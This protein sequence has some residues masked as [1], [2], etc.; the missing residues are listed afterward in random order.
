MLTSLRIFT[1]TFLSTTQLF[2]VTSHTCASRGYVIG[3]GV[4]FICEPPQS[5]NGTLAIKPFQT[6]AVD[7]SSNL[8]TRS[9][10]AHSRNAF[11][12]E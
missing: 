8:Q 12:I 10:T 2:L 5:L 9:T 6:L 11:L 1:V 3:V 4:L 7:F